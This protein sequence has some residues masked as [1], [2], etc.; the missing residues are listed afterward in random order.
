MR[1]L[2]RLTAIA[3]GSAVLAAAALL[4][5]LSDAA[6]PAVAAENFAAQNVT[7]GSIAPQSL[8][9]Q[10]FVSQ[11]FASQSFVAQD[12]GICEITSA[13]LTWGVKESFR[14]YITSTIANG[15]WEVSDGAEYETPSFSWHN[16]AGTFDAATGEGSVSFVGTVQFTGHGGV[17]DLMFANPTIEFRG[18]GSANLLL[19]ARSNNPQGE[20]VLEAEQVPVARIDNI[21]D[22]DANAGTVSISGT[23]V[24]LTA[25]GTKA[26]AEMYATGSELDPISLMLNFEACGEPAGEEP[27]GDGGGAA[28][29]PTAQPTEEVGEAQGESPEGDGLDFALWPVIIIAAAGFVVAFAVVFFVSSRKNKK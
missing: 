18:D 23:T 28:E 27:G 26:F 21:G 2:T 16:G 3:A 24:M 12:G 11:S 25:D 6:N 8:V 14:S 5:P 15:G 22:V 29:E 17:L 20:L 10:S 19:D 1:S 7:I 4:A 9:S 13:D